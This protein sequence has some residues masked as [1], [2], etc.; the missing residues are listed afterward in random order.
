LGDAKN[1]K[2]KNLR[3][4]QQELLSLINKI[5]PYLNNI[6]KPMSQLKIVTC[7]FFIHLEIGRAEQSFLY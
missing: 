3:L 1:G 7:Q 5:S 4:K 6:S 2:G